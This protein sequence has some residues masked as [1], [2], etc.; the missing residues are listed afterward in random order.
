MFWK[1]KLHVMRL[2]PVTSGV[3]TTN[4]VEIFC[5]KGE[6]RGGNGRETARRGEPPALAE[7][8]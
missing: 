7:R 1:E 4:A 8:G 6:E 2:K 5:S 3:K